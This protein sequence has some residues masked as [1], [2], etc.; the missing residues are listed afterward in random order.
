MNIIEAFLVKLP[1]M[2]ILALET[3]T[4][5]GSIAVLDDNKGLIGEVRININVAY[6]ERLMPSVDWL[7]NASRLTIQDIDVFAV[8]IG[9]GSF[10]GLRI[11]LSTLKGFAYAT[12]RPVVSVP[13]LDAFARAL[14]SGSNFI[15]PMIDARK[16]EVYT[17]LYKWEDGLLR[18]IIP[19]IAVNPLYFLN[20]LKE[21]YA[22]KKD[23]GHTM[24][25]GEGAKIYKDLINDIFKPDVFFA[26]VS[27]MFPAAASVAE[28]AIEKAKSGMFTDPVTLTPFY[29]RQ[30]EAEVHWK[31]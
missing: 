22:S 26:P 24:F 19:E 12:N 31:V 10:T 1:F 29:L 30:S 7:L 18:K 2:K 28:I 16:N 5:A 8:S 11:G 21:F 14:P 6:A 15:C 23:K 27:S 13:T 4:M 17:G 3:A 9:P 20:G 25:M